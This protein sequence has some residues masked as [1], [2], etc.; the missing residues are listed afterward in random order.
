MTI[1]PC[2][3]EE[4]DTRIVL[5]CLHLSQIGSKSVAVRSVDTDVVVLA[6]VFFNNLNIEHIWI[7]FVVGKNSR[8]IAIPK[9]KLTSHSNANKCEAL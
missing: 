5:H 7:H 9:L 2:N 1:D 6:I 8:L 4:P 3:R